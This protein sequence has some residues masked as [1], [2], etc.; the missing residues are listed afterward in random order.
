M[1]ARIENLIEKKLVGKTMTMSLAN[2][3]TT[4]LWK[5]FMQSRQQI[6]VM[7][8]SELYSLQVYDDNYFKNFNVSAEFKK[9]ALVEVPN[10]E[11]IPSGMQPFTLPSGLYAVFLHKGGPAKGREVFQFIFGEWLPNSGYVLD[12]RP[13]FEILGDQYKNEHPDAEEEIWI[14]IRFPI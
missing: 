10:F 6:S 13:H 3:K 8:G 11:N 9:W 12:Q 7:L 2:N 5:S 4:D 14:P 1:N